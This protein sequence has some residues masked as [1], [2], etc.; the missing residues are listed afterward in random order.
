MASEAPTML[1]RQRNG[2]DPAE[3]G[4]CLLAETE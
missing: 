1:I 4:A 2:G 3:F